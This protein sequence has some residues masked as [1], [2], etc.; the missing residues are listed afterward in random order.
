MNKGLSEYYLQ[1]LALLIKK[2]DKNQDKNR[3]ILKKRERNKLRKLSK[4]EIR[5][6]EMLHLVRKMFG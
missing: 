4:K 1:N 3:N 2:V 6:L 5:Q